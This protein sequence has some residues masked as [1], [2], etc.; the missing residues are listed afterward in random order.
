MA[1][2][3]AYVS[4]VAGGHQLL[5][6]ARL[7]NSLLG[8]VWCDSAYQ[9]LA[10]RVG[11]LRLRIDIVKNPSRHQF[12]PVYPRWII[13]RSFAWLSAHRRLGKRDLEHTIEA[14][15]TW[16]KVAA[17]ASMIDRLAPKPDT[18]QTRNQDRC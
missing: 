10:R 12:I 9:G 11:R 16:I 8:L 6:R 17:I 13:E 18:P 3:S 4:D 5:R 2:T 14:A 15:E 1:V 7:T